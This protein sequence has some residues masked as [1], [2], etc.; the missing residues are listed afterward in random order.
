MTVP[1]DQA[2]LRK[3]PAL[4]GVHV[5]TWR[6]GRGDRCVQRKWHNRRR[7]GTLGAL[8]QGFGGLG[9]RSAL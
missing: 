1:L 3:G 9:A 7:A 8:S 2:T 6:S 5:A 4:G